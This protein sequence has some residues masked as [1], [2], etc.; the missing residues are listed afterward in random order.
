M[1]VFCLH[2]GMYTVCVPGAHGEQMKAF[3]PLGLEL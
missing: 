2:V 1:C 3:N